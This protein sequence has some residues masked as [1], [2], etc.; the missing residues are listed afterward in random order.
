MSPSLLVC[1]TNV[2][3]SNKSHRKEKGGQ[4]EREE[5]RRNE[6]R[7]KARIRDEAVRNIKHRIFKTVVN[8]LKYL[9]E[10][11]DNMCGQM[12]KH[13]NDSHGDARGEIKPYNIR[14]IKTPAMSLSADVMLRDSRKW[15]RGHRNY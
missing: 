5:G 1:V 14:N 13:K 15:K 3:S 2:Q 7:S 4:E 9:M 8:M 10:K 6:G 11:V 12:G